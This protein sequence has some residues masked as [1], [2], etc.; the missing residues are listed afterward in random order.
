MYLVVTQRGR[1]AEERTLLSFNEKARALTDLRKNWA[2]WKLVDTLQMLPV[3][4]VAYVLRMAWV[5]ATACPTRPSL[6]FLR[7]G[8][9]MLTN[10]I[11]ASGMLD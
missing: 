10:K 7:V 11:K 4:D 5:E 6:R 2:A 3:P 9:R 8:F 1:H